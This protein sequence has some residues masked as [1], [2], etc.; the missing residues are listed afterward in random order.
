MGLVQAIAMGRR[1]AYGYVLGVEVL[2]Q[3]ND[4]L[5]SISANARQ[6]QR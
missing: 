5:K 4:V 2:V 3:F 6:A 1:N